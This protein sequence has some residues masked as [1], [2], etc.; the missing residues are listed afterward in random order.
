MPY[1][2]RKPYAE[3]LAGATQVPPDI[4]P[5]SCPPVPLLERAAAILKEESTQLPK[6][7]ASPPAEIP[8]YLA[9]PG[10][11]P[12]G[13]VVL[14][15]KAAVRP[16]KTATLVMSVTNESTTAT[17]CTVSATDLVC[18]SGGRIGAGQVRISPPEASV[19]P[20]AAWDVGI[21]IE[22]PLG[23]TPGQY[24]GLLVVSGFEAVHAVL[25]LRVIS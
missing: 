25:T 7:Q 23:I 6:Y 4:A 11:L 13:M 1:F 18:A 16:G 3:M 10:V 9:H 2:Q 14:Q 22:V 8:G 24:S 21:A 5:D 19:A 20:G 12:E 15:P 17:L